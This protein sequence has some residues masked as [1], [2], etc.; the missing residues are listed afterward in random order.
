LV[1]WGGQS[2]AIDQAARVCAI[3]VAWLN[4]QGVWYGFAPDFVDQ[5]DSW[6]QLQNE[7]AFLHGNAT[8]TGAVSTAPSSGSS[9]PVAPTVVPTLTLPTGSGAAPT[10]TTTPSTG[11]IA[12]GSV[13]GPG[14]AGPPSIQIV[15]FTSEVQRDSVA[16]L[17]IRTVPFVTCTLS[18]GPPP[19]RVPVTVQNA[20]PRPVD[21]N[22]YISWSWRI[23]P[24]TP[25]GV[26]GVAVTCQEATAT[27]D[28]R[29]T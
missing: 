16:R 2:L 11:I 15:D 28:I 25:T 18:Y 26:G 27:L 8:A 9:G 4:R 5:S 13:I 1:Y 7:V 21:A 12:S 6:V 10:V 19:T 29:I 23:E 3:D 22:G 14:P 20:G 17:L 24:N